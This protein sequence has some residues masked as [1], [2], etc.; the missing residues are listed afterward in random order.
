MEEVCQNCEYFVR[1]SLSPSTYLWGDC[2]KPASSME[3]TNGNKKGV[4]KWADGTCRDFKPK[5]EA[6]KVGRE[7]E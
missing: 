5:Q 3:Q 7:N 6:S 2:R 1:M 4:F